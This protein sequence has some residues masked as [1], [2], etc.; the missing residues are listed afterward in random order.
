MGLNSTSDS[1]IIIR[2]KRG[3]EA[4][5][6]TL[7]DTWCGKLFHFSFRYLKSHEQAEEVVQDTLLKIWT[8][9]QDLDETLPLSPLLFTICQRIC[10]D[11]LRR[12]AASGAA[13][14][15]LWQNYTGLCNSTE[16]AVL[17]ADLESFTEEALGRLPA[18]Q[19]QVFRLSRYEGLSHAEI[20]ERMQISR[21]TVKKHS[22]EALKRMR[23]YF[24]K[25]GSA[26]MVL[27]FTVW[28][29]K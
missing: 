17:L 1:Y 10:I 7:F 23:L 15:A 26:W 24:S 29:K 22:A 9:R 16:E 18:Q 3:D 14:E 5:F 2:I 21:E 8:I 6:R 28:I 25:Y 12:A 11:L 13:T 19:Q 27:L 20:A 4:A